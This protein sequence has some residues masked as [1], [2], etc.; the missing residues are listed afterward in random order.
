M[1]ELLFAITYIT[2]NT[3]STILQQYFPLLNKDVP[4]KIRIIEN[5]FECF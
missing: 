2:E 3:L 5:A 1:A 4:G